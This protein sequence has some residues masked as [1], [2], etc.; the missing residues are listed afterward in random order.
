MLDFGLSRLLE[1]DTSHKSMS[2][3]CGTFNYAAPE[4]FSGKVR[5]HV[6]LAF[7]G[8]LYC[9]ENDNFEEWLL[10]LLS[11]WLLQYKISMPRSLKHACTLCNHQHPAAA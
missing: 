2:N 3:P 7:A 10:Y 9:I 1:N 5:V 4:V 6:F 11:C 8:L